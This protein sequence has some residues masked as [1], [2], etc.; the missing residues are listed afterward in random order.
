[1]VSVGVGLVALTFGVGIAAGFGLGAAARALGELALDFLDRFGLRRMLDDG[2]FARQAIERGF[3]EL[4]FAVG[5]FRL[6]F[7]AIEIAYHF[8]DRNDVAGIDLGFVFLRPA[9]P[10]RA[11]D[12]RA[13]LERLERL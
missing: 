1:M 13:A 2:D 5:L 7:R 12:A 10:H 8:G 3:I 6:R 11:L 4:A 9:R